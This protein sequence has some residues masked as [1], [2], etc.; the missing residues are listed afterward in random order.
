MLLSTLARQTGIRLDESRRAQSSSLRTGGRAPV[1]RPPEIAAPP[2]EAPSPPLLV[3]GC[4]RAEKSRVCL[5]GRRISIL[6]HYVR[7]QQLSAKALS[8]PSYNR[9]QHLRILLLSPF[10]S[11]L[12]FSSVFLFFPSRNPPTCLSS[13]NHHGSS[14]RSPTRFALFL[15][16][17]FR[18][19]F[20]C[21]RAAN[22][23]DAQPRPIHSP[24]SRSPSSRRPS[25]C[26]YVFPLASLPL[27]PPF[28]TSLARTFC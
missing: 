20:F 8:F 19:S 5:L 24:R 12:A 28:P 16:S 2:C 4:L 3:L 22:P 6:T 27:S 7:R 10:P 14:H 13:R 1:C 11:R 25:L 23:T 26:L 17:S 21:S 18:V 15:F 9:L